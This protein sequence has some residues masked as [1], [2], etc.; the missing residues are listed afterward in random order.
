LDESVASSSSKL[1]T[2]YNFYLSFIIVQT[3]IV[4]RKLM[5]AIQTFLLE[6]PSN[7]YIKKKSSK[8]NPVQLIKRTS[9]Y[10]TRKDKL[11]LRVKD[12]SIIS[13]VIVPFLNNYQLQTKK[14]LDYSD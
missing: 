12:L 6:L 2:G 9:K 13:Q 5:E 8:S 4:L 10:K 1:I 3:I 11:E 7:N 14:A